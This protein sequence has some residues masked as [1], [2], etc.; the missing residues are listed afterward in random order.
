[1]IRK[2]LL[3]S[4]WPGRLDVVSRDPMIMLDGSHNP[5]G[6]ATTVGVLKGLRL[7]PLTFVLG[8]MDDK[9]SRGMVRALA[10]VA[11][12]IISTQPR[13]KRALP[14]EKLG[15]IVSEEFTG[16]QDVFEDSGK[17][18]DRGVK[19]ICGNGLCVIGSLYLVGE[20]LP[21]W[22]K[23]GKTEPRPPHKV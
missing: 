2:G 20:A 5:D 10:P 13:Y 8:C 6:I 23:R 16:R 4:K 18:F 14:A 15:V 11:E 9:D 3:A 21:W 22:H 19:D 7:T 1:E 17:A 12:K